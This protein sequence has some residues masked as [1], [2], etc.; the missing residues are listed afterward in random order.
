MCFEN[1]DE[2]IAYYQ[3]GATQREVTSEFNISRDKFRYLLLYE[4]V[5]IRRSHSKLSVDEETQQEIVED[6]QNNTTFAEI[7]DRYGTGRKQV[8]SILGKNKVE[9]RGPGWHSSETNRK[10]EWDYEFFTRETPETYYWAGFI[11]AD[12]CLRVDEKAS[13][14]QIEVALSTK[15]LDHLKEFCDAVDISHDAINFRSDA[16][17][18]RVALNKQGLHEDVER[19]GIVPNKTYDWHDPEPIPEKYLPHFLRGWFD[20]DGSVSESQIQL[21]SHKHGTRYYARQLKRLGYEGTHSFY[22]QTDGDVY[23]V[24]CV[25]GRQQILDVW[26]TCLKTDDPYMARKHDRFKRIEKGKPIDVDVDPQPVWKVCPD[27]YEDL[28]YYASVFDAADDTDRTRKTVKSACNKTRKSAGYYWRFDGQ[29]FEPSEI[30]TNCL[31]V[32]QL[33]PE[34]GDK[35]NRFRSLKEA[36][37]KVGGDPSALGKACRGALNTSA[38]YSWEYA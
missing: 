6:Y 33:D 26:R 36:A 8:Y 16:D 12:G 15:D 34:T 35:L 31:E 13:H 7:K 27:T 10:Y 1:K 22:E 14:D 9:L 24:L 25:A 3:S 2:I 11:L 21:C 19:F 38:G 28:E 32:L 17:I 30:S 5:P 29:S 18:C 37:S 20:G 23:D 4:D